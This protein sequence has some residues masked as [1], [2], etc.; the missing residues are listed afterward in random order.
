MT[1]SGTQPGALGRLGGFAYR[2]RG[3]VILAW[4]AALAVAF[5]LSTLLSGPFNADYSAPS[6]DSTAAGDLLTQ[7]F[8][9]Q[10]GTRIAVVV[11]SDKPVSDPAT[12]SEIDALVQQLAT[13]PHVASV[14]RPGQTPGAISADGRTAIAELRMDT[15]NYQDLKV[16]DTKRMLAVAKAAQRPGLEVALG[17]QAVQHAEEGKIGSEGIGLL[18]ATIILLLVFGSVVAAGLPIIVAVTGLAVSSLLTGVIAAAMP[19]PDWSTALAAMMGIGIGIDYALLM[20]TR[21]REWRAGG[22]DPEAATIATLDTAGRS[23]LLAGAT[24]MVSMFGLFAMGLSFMRGAAMVTIVAVAVVLAAALT[25]FPALLGFAGSRIDRLRLPMPRRRARAAGPAGGQGW[26]RWN[27]LVARHSIISALVG[28]ALLA[29][30][31]SPFL[32]VRFGFPDAGNDPAGS[33]NR[34]A[35]GMTAKAFGPGSNGPL[36]LAIK[37]PAGESTAALGRLQADLSNTTGVAAVTPA[38]LNPAG[39]TAVMSVV[40]ATA[41]GTAAAEDLVR[42]LR[43]GVLPA[44]EKD[45]GL[46]AY[47]GGVTAQTVDTTDNIASRLPLLIGG[48]VLLSM[49]LLLVAFRSIAIALKAAVMNLLSVAAAYGVVAWVLQG[50]V[51]G[52][53]VGIDTPTPLAAFVPVLMFAVLFGLSMDYEVFLIAR[54]R[55]AWLRTHDNSEAILSGMAG[56]ARVITAAAAIMVAVFAAFIPDPLIYLKIIGLGMA[57][58]IFI[59]ATIVR[60]LLVPAVMH[61]LGAANWWLPRRVSR[62]V[63]QLH[64]EGRPERYA[65]TAEDRSPTLEP[66]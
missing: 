53:L 41:P 2:H 25:L 60:L 56:T 22:L 55:E 58:A 39:D 1:A 11:R 17:G 18:A 36:V 45:T 54:M 26:V 27:N 34:Q 42:R 46:T 13:M 28:V 48:V 44:A 65:R 19:V 9:A 37:L 32:G 59:D 38:Q 50:G 6:S 29:A 14:L 21:F 23:V 62:F 30:L 49:L 8:P 20:V 31:A 10:A 61:L 64:V 52:K 33:S 43:D 57:A 24:V 12:R 15:V 66:A 63:P 51:L 7:R 4:L 5:G 3:Q 47:V 16:A 35:Y 40:P